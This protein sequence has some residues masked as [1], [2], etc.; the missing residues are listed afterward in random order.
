MPTLIL[1]RHAKTEPD[2]VDDWHRE[3][4]DRGR[5]QARS[6]GPR[7]AAV[8][9]DTG[10]TVLVSTAL[11]AAQ[12]WEEIAPALGRGVDVLELPSLY[13]FDERDVLREI[14]D[15]AADAETVLVVGHNPGI[16]HLVR[17]LIDH[18]LPEDDSSVKYGA[19]RTCRGAVLRVDGAWADLDA[20]RCTLRAVLSPGVD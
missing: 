20:G 8:R 9:G 5:D 7:I 10:C 16:S 19:L 3:L 11:R 18:D 14:Q 12:T 13:V 1:L 17:L 4:T 15:R 6:I 2:A